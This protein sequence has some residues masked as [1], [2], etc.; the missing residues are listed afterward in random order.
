MGFVM[1]PAAAIM[2]DA[3][4]E[5]SETGFRTELLSPNSISGLTKVLSTDRGNRTGIPEHSIPP[6]L[7]AWLS[8]QIVMLNTPSNSLT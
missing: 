5:T 4:D 6:R 2:P 8:L 1:V 7:P 3:L